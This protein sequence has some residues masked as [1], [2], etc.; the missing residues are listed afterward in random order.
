MVTF[1]SSLN[2]N[3]WQVVTCMIII[4]AN[5]QLLASLPQPILHRL[6]LVINTP[7]LRGTAKFSITLSSCLSEFLIFSSSAW[8]FFTYSSLLLFLKCINQILFSITGYMAS[9]SP[10]PGEVTLRESINSAILPSLATSSPLVNI[11]D[12]LVADA[13]RRAS[14]TRRPSSIKYPPNYFS[15]PTE[16]SSSSSEDETTKRRSKKIKDKVW[17]VSA[18]SNAC[19]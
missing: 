7:F 1:S 17:N 11:A 10:V 5:I 9:S 6:Q 15:S 3:S 8:I 19:V 18:L 2:F 13:I 16:E 14:L 12:R 4:S